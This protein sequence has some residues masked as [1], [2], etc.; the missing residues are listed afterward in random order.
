MSADRGFE[1][2]TKASIFG[3]P[4]ISIAFGRD[5][6]GRIRITKG[7]LAVG[8][9][10]YGGIVIAQ[11]GAGIVTL[12]QFA[13]GLLAFGQLALGLL[14]GLGQVAGGVMAIGQVVWAFYG[15]CQVGWAKYMWSPGRTDMEAV[16]MFYTVKMI[17]LQ[18]GGIDF[19]E[20]IRGGY[21]WGS[22]WLMSIFK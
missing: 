4:L 11:F 22:K 19:G 5:P 16:S 3:F 15:L 17:I 7:L 18:E 2:R 8:Q 9:F 1:W 10:A 20:V 12:S 13:V 6:E 21:E 14:L